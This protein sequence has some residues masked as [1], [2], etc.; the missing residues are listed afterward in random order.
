MRIFICVCRIYFV[1]LQP[2]MRTYAKMSVIG[3]FPH[4][5]NILQN[6]LKT[7]ILIDL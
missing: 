7:T 6:V 3:R 1:S 2:K 4:L 5:A